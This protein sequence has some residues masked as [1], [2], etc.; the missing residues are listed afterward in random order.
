MTCVHLGQITGVVSRWTACQFIH[1]MKGRNKQTNKNMP[2]KFGSQCL[3]QLHI[4]SLLLIITSML[5]LFLSTFPPIVKTCLSSTPFKSLHRPSLLP[6]ILQHQMC[7]VHPLLFIPSCRLPKY[8][9][10][11]YLIPKEPINS[12]FS[13]V[14]PL[15]VSNASPYFK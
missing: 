2:L 3:S 5:C 12:A 7:P 14:H 4:T 1:A 13:W 6:N 10:V 15:L 11:L 8:L 9:A